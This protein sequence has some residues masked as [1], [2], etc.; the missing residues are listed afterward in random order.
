MYIL[1]YI[2]FAMHH[3]C[4]FLRTTVEQFVEVY[5]SVLL[6]QSVIQ[7]CSH[8]QSVLSIIFS[9]ARNLE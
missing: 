5:Q 3:L 6:Q 1:G 7:A 9:E 4:G 8:V 2:T